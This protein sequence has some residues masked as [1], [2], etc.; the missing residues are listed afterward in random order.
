MKTHYYMGWMNSFLPE[1]LAKALQ[2]DLTD[3]KSLVLVSA[4]PFSAEAD[5]AAERSW[6][7]HAGIEFEEYHVIN[8]S[9]QKEEAQALLQEASAIFLL[10]GNT[11]EQNDFLKDY[12]L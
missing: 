6:L 11:I 7:A 2:E 1:P 8:R 3:W 5:G 4:V 9:M 10:G 12:G